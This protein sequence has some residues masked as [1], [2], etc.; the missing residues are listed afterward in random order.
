[1][2]AVRFFSKADVEKLLKPYGCTLRRTLPDGTEVWATG[3]NEVFTLSPEDLAGDGD[4]RYDFWQ[5]NR[6]FSAVIGPTLPP[7]FGGNGG[8]PNNH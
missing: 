2:I 6:L 1:M 8:K 3:W 5:I 4:L 7:G